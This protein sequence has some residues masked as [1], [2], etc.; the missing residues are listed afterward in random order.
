MWPWPWRVKCGD[1]TDSDWGEFR[2]RYAIHL[3]TLV[4]MMAFC[5][6]ETKSLF[7]PILDYSQMDIWKLIIVKFASNINTWLFVFWLKEV[8]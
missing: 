1:L 2:W 6:F 8:C 5:L 4:K 7:E 3:S